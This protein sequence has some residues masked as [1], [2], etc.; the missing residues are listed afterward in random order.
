MDKN[1]IRIVN[2]VTA[3]IIILGVILT[4][5]VAAYGKEFSS[6]EALKDKLLNPFL[7]LTFLIFAIAALAAIVFPFLEMLRN[8]RK[9][10]GMAAIIAGFVVLALISYAISQN[11]FDPE[12]LQKLRSTP[13]VSRS[14][15]AGLIFTYFV[16]GFTILAFIVSSVVNFLRR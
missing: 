4:L 16:A 6:N 3:V 12:Q 2:I 9:L 5:L 14:V 8:P 13:A 15:G 11:H 7:A 10:L 1:L